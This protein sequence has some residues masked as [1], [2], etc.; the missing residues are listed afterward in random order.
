MSINIHIDFH[1]LKN[2]I[3]RYRESIGCCDV[4]SYDSYISSKIASDLKVFKDGLGSYPN[5]MTFEEWEGIIQE[6][7][8]GFSALDRVDDDAKDWQAQTD[9]AYKMREKAV[10]LF[11]KHLYSLWR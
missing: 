3:R 6:M 1:F 11:A 9:K 4:S 7:I 8:D 5:G 2:L 10:K